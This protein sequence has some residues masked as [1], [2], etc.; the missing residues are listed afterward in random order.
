MKQI[1]KLIENTTFVSRWFHVA[2]MTKLYM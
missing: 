2:A 1:N